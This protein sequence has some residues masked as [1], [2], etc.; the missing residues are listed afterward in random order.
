METTNRLK[1]R[2]KS[3]DTRRRRQAGNGRDR[4]AER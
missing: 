2:R 3:Y 4:S 1:S